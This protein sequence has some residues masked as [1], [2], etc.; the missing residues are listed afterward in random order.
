M[1][2]EVEYFPWSVVNSLVKVSPYM[3]QR[4]E[5][6]LQLRI[7]VYPNWDVSFPLAGPPLAPSEYDSYF[8]QVRSALPELDQNVI[9][10][11]AV[12]CSS[13]LFA[14]LISLCSTCS[15]QD[16]SD[17]WVCNAIEVE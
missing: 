3:L 12:R 4:V 9:T 17:A 10:R 14:N 16:I 1:V 11:V 8:C 2:G 5:I 15:M 13:H 7:E 6:A